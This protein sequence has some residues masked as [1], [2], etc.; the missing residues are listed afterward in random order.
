[1]A[2]S[3]APAV[4]LLRATG[5]ADIRVSAELP[6]LAPMHSLRKI[7]HLHQVYCIH[8]GGTGAQSAMHCGRGQYSCCTRC[9]STLFTLVEA[10]KRR[11]LHLQYQLVPHFASKLMHCCGP[12]LLRQPKLLQ[13]I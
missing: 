3:R 13:T 1:M 11:H 5:R 10:K 8:K 6:F 2:P 4:L 9:L 12:S 7:W